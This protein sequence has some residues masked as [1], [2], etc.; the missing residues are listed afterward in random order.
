MIKAKLSCLSQALDAQRQRFPSVLREED[1]HDTELARES[2]TTNFEKLSLKVSRNNNRFSKD[3][4][5]EK[6]LVCGFP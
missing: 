1:E 3:Q 6:L 2:L 4:P 5:L